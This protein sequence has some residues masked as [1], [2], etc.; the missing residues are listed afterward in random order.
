[1][2]GAKCHCLNVN[3]QDIKHNSYIKEDN[4]SF[5]NS[6]S[7]SIVDNEGFKT[8]E[9]RA[10]RR[11][12]MLAIN[13][14]RGEES[15]IRNIF[16]SGVITG[17]LNLIQTYLRNRKIDVKDIVQVSHYN[18]KYKS[19]KISIYQRDLSTVLTRICIRI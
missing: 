8:V 2:P 7:K 14:L 16:I 15:P 10:Q 12:R 9:S 1:M 17:N 4:E 19:F 11:R 13:W 18:S 5:I 3:T 6:S